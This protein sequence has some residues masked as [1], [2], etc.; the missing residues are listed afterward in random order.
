MGVQ[1][2][3][4]NACW[5]CLGKFAEPFPIRGD[6][7]QIDCTLCGVYSVTGSS[8]ASTFPLPDDERYR[9]SHWVK[10]RQLDR[11]RPP[12]FDGNSANE[13]ALSLA[14][15]EPSEK[16]DILLASIGKSVK[17]AGEFIKLDAD[18]QYSLACASSR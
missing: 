7:V 18:R 3:G 9:M 5:I 16:L 17:H 6:Q 15:Y 11:Q 4:M 8:V 2:Q 10:Q 14:R 1:M 13:I 12:V